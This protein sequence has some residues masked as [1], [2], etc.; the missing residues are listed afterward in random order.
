[1]REEDY[2]LLE[3][4]EEKLQGDYL[5]S[6]L[7]V[8]RVDFSEKKRLLVFKPIER[9]EYDHGN[10]FVVDAISQQLGRCPV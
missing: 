2:L 3:L 1:M 8:A 4:L 9:A 6:R 5:K 10:E 7:S